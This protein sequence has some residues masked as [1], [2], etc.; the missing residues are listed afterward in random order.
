MTMLV[1]MIRDQRSLAS[2]GMPKCRLQLELKAVTEFQKLEIN[3]RGRLPN[4]M[5]RSSANEVSLPHD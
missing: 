1:G 2:Q 5:G 3:R 4:P